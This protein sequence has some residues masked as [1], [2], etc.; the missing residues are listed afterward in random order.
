MEVPPVEAFDALVHVRR[1]H[2]TML[3]SQRPRLAIDGAPLAVQ[4]ACYTPDDGI[5]VAFTGGT[6]TASLSWDP[7]TDQQ[8]AALTLVLGGTTYTGTLPIPPDLGWVVDGQLT[9][10]GGGTVHLAAFL[11][12]D[13]PAC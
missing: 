3:L 12:Y 9:A 8:V 13:L 7:G 11:S 10:A 4:S 5:A 6:L 2:A 1:S